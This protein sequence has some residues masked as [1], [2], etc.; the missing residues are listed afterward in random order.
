M[1]F[2]VLIYQDEDGVFIGEVPTC[3]GVH[4][5]GKTLEELY[6]NLREV[7]QLYME[8]HKD[9]SPQVHY[10]FQ[11]LTLDEQAKNSSRKDDY[12]VA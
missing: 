8:T 12:Q 3:K 7:L 10:S 4:T 9:T 11:I 1:Q 2:P 6:S 5:H